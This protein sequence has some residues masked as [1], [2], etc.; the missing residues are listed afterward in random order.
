MPS[1]DEL[2]WAP[3]TELAQR[4]RQGEV[5]PSDVAGQVVAR[6]EAVNPGLNAFITSS[7]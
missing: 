3:A 6:I 1:S 7:P 4:I 2:C 5:T